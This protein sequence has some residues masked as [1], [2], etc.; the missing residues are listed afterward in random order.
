MDDLTGRKNIS[1]GITIYSHEDH[2]PESRIMTV[3]T[4]IFLE[5]ELHSRARTRAAALGVSLAEYIR[6]LVDQDLAEFP[7]SS[8][9][10]IIFDPGTSEPSDIAT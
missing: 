6:R 2:Y 9:R 5:A 4:Q 1:N 10:P 7:R 3:R 8:H